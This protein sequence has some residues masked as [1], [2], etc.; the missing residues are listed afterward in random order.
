LEKKRES[1]SELFGKW[2]AEWEVN[3]TEWRVSGGPLMGW[4]W[5]HEK[6][7]HKPP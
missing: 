2:E 6:A 7:R 1:V 3:G 4:P 5:P